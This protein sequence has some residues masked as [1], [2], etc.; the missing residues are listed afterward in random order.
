MSEI[1]RNLT[2]TQYR[3]FDVHIYVSFLHAYAYGGPRFISLTRRTFVES[4]ENL[5]QEKLE[6]GV[7]PST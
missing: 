2:G 5:I 6:V 4:E 3:I 1:E 7:N